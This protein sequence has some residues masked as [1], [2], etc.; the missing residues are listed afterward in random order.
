[1]IEEL[2][3]T[4]T[5][6][7]QAHNR[8]DFQ[9]SPEVERHIKQFPIEPG[10]SIE[11]LDAWLSFIEPDKKK[12]PVLLRQYASLSGKFHCLGVDKNFA[13]TPGLLLSVDLTKSPE[14]RQKQFLGPNYKKIM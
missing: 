8:F 12:L 6:S 4:P 1:M 11:R 14:K 2:A 5:P 10:N 9:L 13:D 7:V 3:I